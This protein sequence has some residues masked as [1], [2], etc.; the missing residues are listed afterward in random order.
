MREH[1]ED[2]AAAGRL[3]VVPARPLRRV[4]L[5]V[6]HPPAEIEPD[7]QHAA[8]EL[9]LVQFAQLLEAGQ[10]QLVLH[11]AAL[12]AGALG[13]A[14]QRQRIFERLGDRLFEIDVLAGGERGTGRARAGRRSALASK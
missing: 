4:Q 7:R 11:D 8:E 3:A 10:E 5:A 6:E 1:I 12:P 13:G 14:R 2:Q 9:G